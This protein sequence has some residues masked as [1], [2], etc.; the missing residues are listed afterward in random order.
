[1]FWLES[2]IVHR[3]VSTWNHFE[4]VNCREISINGREFVSNEEGNG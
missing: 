4:G 2:R 1:M 3:K